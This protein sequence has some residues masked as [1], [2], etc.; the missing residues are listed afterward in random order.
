M[1][2]QRR[3]ESSAHEQHSSPISRRDFIARG[4]ASGGALLLTPSLTLL[5]RS[6][7]LAADPTCSL[8]ALNDPAR[9]V[10]VLIFDLAGGANLLGSNV[11]VG[12][13]RGQ[14]D[15]L[16]GSANPYKGV[17][18]KAGGTSNPAGTAGSDGF[19]PAGSNRPPQELGIGN[20]NEEFGLAFHPD[21]GILAGMMEVTDAAQTRPRVDGLALCTASADDTS[22]NPFNVAFW[23][24]R[25]GLT[26]QLAATLNT[27]RGGIAG[28]STIPQGSFDPRFRPLLITSPASL[29]AVV[30]P[31]THLTQ[32]LSNPADRDRIMGFMNRMSSAALSR[33]TQLELADQL[34]HSLGC[35]SALQKELM[36]KNP[37]PLQF[38]TDGDFQ[39]VFPGITQTL[40]SDLGKTAAICHALLG[41]FA[42]VGTITLGGYDYHDGTL[43]GGR[44]KDKAAGRLIGRA[45]EIFRRKGKPVLIYVFTDGGVYSSESSTNT[46]DPTWNGDDGEKGGALLFALHPTAARTSAPRLRESFASPDVYGRQLGEYRYLNGKIGAKRSAVVTGGDVSALARAVL[47]NYFALHTEDLGEIRRRLIETTGSEPFSSAPGGFERYVAFKKLIA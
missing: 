4:L 29:T 46:N 21:S 34:R 22:S 11:I 44:A 2:K 18:L 26:G 41:G 42:G 43:T 15:L 40:S 27:T 33:F 30:G 5:A 25:S 20:L 39:A 7:A 38:S 28:K 24:A 12:G 23:L 14:K 9:Q 10:P 6:T 37:A 45:L 13:A 19:I 3:L 47:A 16:D 31:G 32:M 8:P 35:S 1:K 36:E 17:G